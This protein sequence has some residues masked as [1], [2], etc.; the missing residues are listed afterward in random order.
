MK[1]TSRLVVVAQDI[2]KNSEIQNLGRALANMDWYRL[3]EK[4]VRGFRVP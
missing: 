2:D 4:N 1:D 3:T